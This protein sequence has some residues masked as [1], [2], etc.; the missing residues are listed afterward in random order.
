MNDLDFEL[1]ANHTV[2]Q[3][4]RF[5]LLKFTKLKLEFF[6]IYHIVDATFLWH[7]F[8]ENGLGTEI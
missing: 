5:I 2:A 1:S 6:T 8:F 4:K 3:S 7:Q